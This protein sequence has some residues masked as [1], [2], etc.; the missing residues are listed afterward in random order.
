[1]KGSHGKT[2]ASLNRRVR[3]KLIGKIVP[4]IGGQYKGYKGRVTQADDKQVILEMST[5]NCKKVAIDRSLIDDK[6]EDKKMQDTAETIYGGQTVYE[7]GKTPMNYNTPSYY[8][9]SPHWG[10]YQSPGYG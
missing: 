2:V 9:Q 5:L 1:M 7:A 3:D 8:P 4:I 10:A 6:V